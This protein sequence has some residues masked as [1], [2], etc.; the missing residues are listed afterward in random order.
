MPATY[1]LKEKSTDQT[2][3]VIRDK[4]SGVSTPTN[5]SYFVFFAYRMK[6]T[7]KNV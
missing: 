4:H 1:E 6:E 3:R 5:N 7:T 2:Y